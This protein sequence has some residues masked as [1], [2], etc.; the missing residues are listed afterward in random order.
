MKLMDVLSFQIK[1]IIKNHWPYL[2][3]EFQYKGKV[4]LS[5]YLTKHHDMKRYRVSGGI[6]SHPGHF[7]PREKALGTHW[8]GGWVGPRAVLD[9]VVRRKI[10]SPHQESNPR[11]P[12]PSTILTELSWLLNFNITHYKLCIFRST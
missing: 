7:T 10:P 9:A 5:L 11:T 8:I 4:K 6:A 2:Q 12:Q 3:F 1:P